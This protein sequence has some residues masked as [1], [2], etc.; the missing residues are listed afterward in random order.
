MLSKIFA[1]RMNRTIITMTTKHIIEYSTGNQYYVDKIDCKVYQLVGSEW[2]FIFN[3]KDVSG[4][5][6]DLDMREDWFMLV[7]NP[8]KY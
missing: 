3:R 5:L 6:P 2:K 4:D 7:N 1:V 8:N